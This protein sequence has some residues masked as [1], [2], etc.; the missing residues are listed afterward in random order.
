MYDD[1]EFK[2]IWKEMLVATLRYEVLP[3]SSR[4]LTYALRV[5]RGD[6]KGKPVPGDI[7]GPPCS[8]GI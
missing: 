8:W 1:N 5:V 2:M 4:N 6:K 7:A 3:K